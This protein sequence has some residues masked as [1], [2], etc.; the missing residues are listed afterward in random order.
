MELDVHS[1]TDAL[2][3][4]E[5]RFTIA[6]VTRREHED[7]AFDVRSLMRG[8]TPDARGWLVNDPFSEEFERLDNPFYPF[9]EPPV[10]IMEADAFRQRLFEIP[11]ASAKRFLVALSTQWLNV[12]KEQDF[13]GRRAGLEEKADV[14]L[15]RFPEGS[16]FYANT[17]GGS[18]EMDYYKRISTCSGVSVYDWDPGLIL[19]SET[20]VG[21]VWAFDPK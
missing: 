10:G 2:G 6:K 15:S 8:D 1:W 19:V 7:W 12:E 13:E 18:G 11:R 5:R 20:E 14:I 4:Y 3:M 17:G 21:M 16:R 9:T